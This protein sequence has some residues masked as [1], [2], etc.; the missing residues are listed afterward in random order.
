MFDTTEPGARSKGDYGYGT[1]KELG[2]LL[3]RRDAEVVL[4]DRGRMIS[5][6]TA[7]LSR[8]VP[9]S[10]WEANRKESATH[11]GDFGS[12]VGQSYTSQHYT[13]SVAVSAALW[14]RAS[15]SVID[16]A[17]KYGYTEVS[18]RTENATDD[19]G[20]SLTLRDS[21]GGYLRFGSMDA[22][23]LYVRTGC[24]LTAEDKRQAREAAPK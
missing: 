21:D 18:G 16:V 13:S 15:Q 7:E 12:T 23:N 1:P 17:A 20:K 14:D 2:T 9:G 11:C 24:Y 10:H 22:A 5:E 19:Q 3:E 8:M 4:A 6:I